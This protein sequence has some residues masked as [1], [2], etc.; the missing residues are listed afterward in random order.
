MNLWDYLPEFFEALASQLK[1]DH[2]RWGN[3]WLSRGIKGQEERTQQK[4]NDYFD[5]FKAVGTP[6]P[7]LKIAG[8]ALICWIRE[9]HPE[10]WEE[11]NTQ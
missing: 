1:E 6:V 8:G 3:V 10:L 7:W 2:K 4:Y 5:Q 11:E 9:K